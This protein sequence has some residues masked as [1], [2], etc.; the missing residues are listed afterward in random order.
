MK[1]SFKKRIAFF[2]TMAV[3]V[4][5]AF[6]FLIIYAVVYF[7]S[8]HH[9]DSGLRFEKEE[10]QSS[11]F[12]K[13]DSIVIK[14]M[15]EWDEAEHS[16]IEVNPTFIQIVNRKGNV[17]FKS[18]N[19]QT[20][21]FEVYPS[22]K[23][24][25][26]YNSQINNQRV[27][28]GQ[29]PIL[30]GNGKIIAQLTLGVSQQESYNVLNN[31]L[32]TLCIAFPIMLVALYSVIL[33]SASKALA[34]VHELIITA[35][36]INDTNI[37]NRLPMPQN[38]DEIHQLAATINE[39][40][41]RIEESI[42]LQKQFTADASHEMRTPLSAMRGIL[43][44]LLR[45]EREPEQYETK[46][47]EVIVQVDRLSLLFDQILQLARLESEKGL[48]KKEPVSLRTAVALIVEKW[49]LEAKKKQI[50]LHVNI[51]QY[52]TVTAHLFL[53]ERILDNLFSNA[54]KYN[55]ERGNIY[56]VWDETKKTLTIEDD[57]PGI[58]PE[59]L[60][61]L[62]NRFYRADNSRNS[63]IQGNGL[64]LAIV[65]KSADLQQIKI[66][67]SSVKCKGTTFTLMFPS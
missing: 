50:Q 55:N 26:F 35:S 59:Q 25:S 5:T 44:V 40:L 39:L 45:K 13:G 66:S 4:T 48:S 52:A 23:K 6:V 21:Q 28:L 61:Y 58:S 49:E 32:I 63:R 43:E 2:N 16:Q 8:Y 47:K 57:G 7:T 62:F 42:Q 33:V 34:P 14:K 3:A 51:S 12:W 65:K 29:F 15:P 41:D 46:I 54:V 11:L 22:I 19:L 67:V 18:A 37:S 9:L 31:L 38:E 56:C 27:R 64:G 20:N 1:L 60:P 36:Q 53:L 17:V 30:N 24:E 10:I